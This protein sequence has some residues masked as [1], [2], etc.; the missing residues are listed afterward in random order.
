MLQFLGVFAALFALD[1]V[2]A[3]YTFALNSKSVFGSSNYAAVLILLS[4]AAAVGYT[5]NPWLLIPAAMGAW[6]GT[7]LA[8][9]WQ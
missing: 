3:R 1:F 9:R 7:A 2:W 8:V 6:C 5:S 4:G